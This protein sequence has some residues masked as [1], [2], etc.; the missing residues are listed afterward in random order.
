MF[1]VRVSEKKKKSSKTSD[2][3]NRDLKEKGIG[4][5]SSTVRRGLLKAGRKARR[6]VKKEN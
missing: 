2:A 6:S 1:L 5:R 3:L 4:I